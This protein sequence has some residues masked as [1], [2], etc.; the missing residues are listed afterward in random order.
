[1]K[2][3]PLFRFT[4]SDK[5]LATES[6]GADREM[7]YYLNDDAVSK[8]LGSS[9]DGLSADLV[10]VAAAIHIA[11]RLAVREKALPEE[12]QRRFQ[13]QVPVRHP[14]EW[15]R[16]DVGGALDEVLA[17]TTGDEWDVRFC[18]RPDRPRLSEHQGSMFPIDPSESIRV[19]LFSGGLDSFASNAAALVENPD[20]HYVCVSATPNRRQESRQREQIGALRALPNRSLTHVRIPCWLESAAE[21]PQEPTRRTRGF[22]FLAL[23]AVSALSAGS[24]RLFLYEN[25]IGAINLPYER[26]PVGVPNSR[27]VHPTTLILVSRFIQTLTGRQFSIENPC[28]F[29]TK[30]QMCREPIMQRMGSTVPST[31]SCDGFPVQRSRAPQCGRCTSCILRRLALDNSGLHSHDT[32]GYACDLYELNQTIWSRRLRGL[33]AMDWQVERLRQALLANPA[34]PALVSEFPDLRQT[35]ASLVKQTGYSGNVIQSHLEHLYRQ[36]CDEWRNFPP[37]QWLLPQRKVA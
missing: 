8:Q 37:R 24:D 22:L 4:A 30:A 31:F 12:W 18:S 1:M 15:Q 28:M 7:H 2:E 32:E 33:A 21:V 35:C 9:L 11:D 19:N 20:V 17:H 26:T 34:W 36:H 13:L 16:T 25:G 27:A 10:D 3:P 14:S 6:P 5:L 23:G 29:Q